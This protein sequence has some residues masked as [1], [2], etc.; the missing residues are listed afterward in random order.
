[1]KRRE[2]TQPEIQTTPFFTGDILMAS[3]E[4]WAPDSDDSEFPNDNNDF[5][6]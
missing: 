1:M 6:F 2:Y 5:G 4:G 3:F